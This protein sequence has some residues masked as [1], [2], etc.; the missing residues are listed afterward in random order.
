[1]GKQGEGEGV[2]QLSRLSSCMSSLIPTGLPGRASR[3][4]R[5]AV[6]EHEAGDSHL[7][8][9][10]HILIYSSYLFLRESIPP[11]PEPETE[12]KGSCCG[13]EGRRGRRRQRAGREHAVKRGNNAISCFLI[14]LQL[15]LL[16]P[17]LLLQQQLS[18]S[19]LL[20]LHPTLR[21]WLCYDIMREGR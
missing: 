3:R 4:T 18:L 6:R 19:A 5:R 2:R 17:L 12:G 13:E 16:Q 21:S 11:P 14:L 20:K 10:M 9:Y 7:Y 1:M 15:L 8:Y